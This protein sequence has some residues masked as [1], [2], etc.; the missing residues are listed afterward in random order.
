M[1]LHLGAFD[2]S[3]VGWVNTD[4]TPHIWIA[5]IPLLPLLLAKLG[6]MDEERYEQH[7]RGVFR[8]LHYVDLCKPLPYADNT[9][10]A[11][12][13]SHVFEHL[14]MDEVENLIDE[15]RRI[16]KKGGVCRVVVPD[17]EKIVALYNAEDPRKFITDIYEVATRSAV[18]NSHHCAFTGSFL[19]SLFKQ[20]GFSNC[21]VMNFKV[22]DC[23]DIDLLDSR[24]E[25]IFFEATK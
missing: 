6:L 18:K 11:I 15:C 19:T 8:A 22:G 24:P 14:F 21:R 25:S 1:K 23:P 4:I 2:K 17:L 13:S 16:L 9:V 12:Y 7:S 20:A 10:E 5:K 3:L